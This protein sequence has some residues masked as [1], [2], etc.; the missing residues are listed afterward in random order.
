MARYAHNIMYVPD[1][2][3]DPLRVNYNA[4]LSRHMSLRKTF[5]KLLEAKK[6]EFTQHLIKGVGKGYWTKIQGAE[7]DKLQRPWGGGHFFPANNVL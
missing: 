3:A 7:L 2:S 6:T 4:V 5:K 1:L